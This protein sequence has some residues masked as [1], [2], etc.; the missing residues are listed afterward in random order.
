MGSS[1]SWKPVAVLSYSC[2]LVQFIA[3][4]LVGKPLY[5]AFGPGNITAHWARIVMMLITPLVV[6]I[7]TLPF[8]LILYTLVERPGILLGKHVIPAMSMASKSC[9]W[10]RRP[11]DMEDTCVDVEMEA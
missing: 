9:Q 8:G 5:D 7:I 4:R 3:M 2:Y 10:Q 1:K 11:G 6:F